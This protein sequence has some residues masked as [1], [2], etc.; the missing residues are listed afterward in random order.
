MRNESVACASL[1]AYAQLCGD[2]SICVDWRSSPILKGLCGKLTNALTIVVTLTCLMCVYTF[3]CTF[4]VVIC[5][6]TILNLK[7]P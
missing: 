4:T 1:E 5:D 7:G 2:K 3:D 6:T